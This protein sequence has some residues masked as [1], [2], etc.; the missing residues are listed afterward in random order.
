MEE[1]PIKRLRAN[2]KATRLP[3][4]AG[5]AKKLEP[6]GDA[7]EATQAGTLLLAALAQ[8]NS[9]ALRSALRAAKTAGLSNAALRTASSLLGRLE[10]AENAALQELKEAE[11]SATN[12]ATGPT[13]LIVFDF[14]LTIA[15]QHMWGTYKTAPLDSI[16]VS[17]ETFVDL[18]LFRSLVRA[19]RRKGAAVAIATFGRADV[20]GKAM[21]FALGAD[22]G[23][24]ILT[25]ADFPDPG[26]QEGKT[27]G[28]ASKV[29][30]C[31]EGSAWLGNKN[32]QLATLAKLNGVAAMDIVLLDDDLHNVKE[33]LKAGVDAR[34]TP[35][36][37]NKAVIK[38]LAVDLGV[39]KATTK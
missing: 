23:M 9:R 31:P 25:P 24:C 13:K 19:L 18:R 6:S 4:I 30:N 12:D 5:Q 20:A 33:A 35:K 3:P 16:P 11:R 14:D 15:R 29:Q 37:L 17:E 7:G 8:R 10:A 21:D 27:P 28:A 38:K 34:H 2:P 39:A 22:H 1:N 32:R 26:H 36:G